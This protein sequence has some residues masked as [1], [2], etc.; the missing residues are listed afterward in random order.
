MRIFK[1]FQKSGS[2]YSH[3]RNPKA[4]FTKVKRKTNNITDATCPYVTKPQKICE[5]M[6]AKGY[7]IVILET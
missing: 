6:S 1:R 3:T 7:Q 4:R 2:D 5:D